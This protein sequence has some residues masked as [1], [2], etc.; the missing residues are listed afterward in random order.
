MADEQP[1][2]KS[3]DEVI[4][5]MPGQFNPEAAKGLT[6]IYQYC[7][8]GDGGKDFYAAI[9]DGALDLQVG[10]HE[11]P[12]ITITVDHQDFLKMLSD[13]AAGQGL[14]MQGKIQVQPLDMALMM[15]MGQLFQS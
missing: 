7:I 8:T 4:E 1:A 3:V 11:S 14:F 13:P 2:P 10:K 12:S 15:R 5:R 9:T 6:A